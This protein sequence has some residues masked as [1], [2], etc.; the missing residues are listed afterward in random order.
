MV[1]L[2]YVKYILDGQ[3]KRYV[4]MSH[5]MI[6]NINYLGVA[7]FY[8]SVLSIQMIFI[9]KKKKSIQMICI[10]ILYLD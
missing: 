2:R 3:R 6:G 10:N 4:N 8:Y 7:Q 9:L 1:I 5:R